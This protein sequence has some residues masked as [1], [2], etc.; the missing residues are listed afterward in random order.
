ML[1]VFGKS[2]SPLFM[3][4]GEIRFN[5]ENIHDEIYKN[6]NLMMFKA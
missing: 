2:H 6:I 3:R 4:S 5:D 1:A